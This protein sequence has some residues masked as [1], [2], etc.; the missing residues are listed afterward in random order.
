MLS[1][2]GLAPLTFRR[3][4]RHEFDTVTTLEFAAAQIDR[5]LGPLRDIVAAVRRGPSHQM[6]GIEE[7]GTLIGFAAIHPD[8]RDAACWWLGWFGIDR[9]RQ[10]GGRGA[11][12]VAAIM[13]E[14]HRLPNCREV[15]LLVAPDNEGALR[16]YRRAGFALHGFAHRTGE[17]IMRCMLTPRRPSGTVPA[18][19]WANAILL[20]VIDARSCRMGVPVAAQ[21]HGEVAFPP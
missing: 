8:R 3:L 17:L 16:L 7:Q 15:R 21:L 2:R 1:E 6:I 13:A 14:L 12:A 11:R 5:F 20:A 10:G 18:R 4:A 9:R 19:F